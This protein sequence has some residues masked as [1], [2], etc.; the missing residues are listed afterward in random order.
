MPIVRHHR[1]PVALRYAIASARCSSVLQLRRGLPCPDLCPDLGYSH[2][3]QCV[4]SHR[5]LPPALWMARVPSELVSWIVRGAAP[6][7]MHCRSALMQPS[8]AAPRARHCP[9]A[10]SV[11]LEAASLGLF[12]R[13]WR[14]AVQSQRKFAIV[15]VQWV[16]PREVAPREVAPRETVPWEEEPR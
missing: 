11:P 4:H 5:P 9:K 6:S 13:S 14:H 7:C 10:R 8:Q 1:T 15:L 2:V 3:A 16:V 12:A